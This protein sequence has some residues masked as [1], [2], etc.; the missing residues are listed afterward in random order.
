MQTN[1]F[2]GITDNSNESSKF[3][4]KISNSRHSICFSLSVW[5]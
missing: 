4:N 5:G 2:S 3:V 1:I